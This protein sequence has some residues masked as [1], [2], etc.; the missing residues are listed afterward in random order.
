MSVCCRESKL[1]LAMTQVMKILEKVLASQALLLPEVA[2]CKSEVE[3]EIQERDKAERK[4]KQL[5]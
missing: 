1:G 3:R 2:K 4:D 5:K